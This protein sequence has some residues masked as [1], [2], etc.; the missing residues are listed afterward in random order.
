MWD[1][2]WVQTVCIACQQM[3]IVE[4]RDPE[5]LAN[6]LDLD[7]TRRFVGPD[8]GPNCLHSLSADDNS[9]KKEILKI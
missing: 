2:I 6:R 3:A 4:K 8:L 9:R 1:L 5:N 7:Q